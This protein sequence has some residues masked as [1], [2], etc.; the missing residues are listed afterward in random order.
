MRAR[1]FFKLP[2]NG[3]FHSPDE[4][5]KSEHLVHR[6]GAKDGVAAK[7][8]PSMSTKYAQVGVYH[9]EVGVERCLLFW[10]VPCWGAR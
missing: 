2:G 10:R 4:S 8:T 3:C 6:R 1:G 7:A 5:L 9:E